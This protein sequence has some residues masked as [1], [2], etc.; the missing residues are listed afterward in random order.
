M[1]F[2]KPEGRAE[3]GVSLAFPDIVDP[4]VLPNSL[5]LPSCSMARGDFEEHWFVPLQYRGTPGMYGVCV[6]ALY[7][8]GSNISLIGDKG[9][10]LLQD[11]LHVEA[12]PSF[13]VEFANS[14][15]ADISFCYRTPVFLGETEV[16][17]LFYYL[18]TLS[19]R[20]C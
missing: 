2:F 16:S 15:K 7:D 3:K 20:C 12:V 9:L 1:L 4:K 18:P 13:S 6:P 5:I 11:G 19:V 14:G 10:H 17:I 8:P